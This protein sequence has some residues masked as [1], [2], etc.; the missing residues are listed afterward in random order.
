M[1]V[2]ARAERVGYG[3][4]GTCSAVAG[5]GSR[6]GSEARSVLDCGK[7]PSGCAKCSDAGEM[8]HRGDR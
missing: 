1:R 4:R 7:V 8:R 3:K 6:N 2:G 5:R